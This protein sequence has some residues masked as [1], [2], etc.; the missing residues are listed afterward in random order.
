M[1][2]EEIEAF[3]IND[4]DLKHAMNPN[5]RRARMTKEEHMLGIW[6][7]RRDSSGSNDSNDDDDEGFRGFKQKKRVKSNIN[8]VSGGIKGQEKKKNDE[9]EDNEGENENNNENEGGDSVSV[10]F[11]LAASEACSHF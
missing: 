2:D 10:E 1:S 8:F 11:L 5:A 4:Y 3:E 6:A 7:D 9:N